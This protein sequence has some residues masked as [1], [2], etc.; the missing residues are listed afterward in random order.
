G[1][2]FG[3]ATRFEFRL[4]PLPSIVGGV[5][6]LP[7]TPE[8]VEGFMRIAGS[9]PD[10]LSTIANV[11]PLPPMPFVPAEHHGEPAIMAIIA[12]AGDT[13]TGERVIAPLRA[14]AEP[15]A[16]MVR[17]MPYSGIYFPED[18]DYR[19]TAAAKTLFMS[20]VDAHD[21]AVIV[22]RLR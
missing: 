15:L 3:V 12:F 20:Q 19:P 2:N 21:A 9:A 22:Q 16:D 13:E 5:L 18:P 14:L 10:E 8:T 17:E 4:H 1:G 6:I 7:A 11:M